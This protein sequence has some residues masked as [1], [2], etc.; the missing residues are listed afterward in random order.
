MDCF[1]CRA[2]KARFC[3]AC[4]QQALTERH[5]RLSEFAAEKGRLEGAMVAGLEQR[6]SLLQHAEGAR[7]HA[8]LKA[9][10]T[11]EIE[12]VR[13][14]TDRLARD[15]NNERHSLRR[16]KAQLKQHDEVL[17]KG[18]HTAW[19]AESSASVE[20]LGAETVVGRRITARRKALLRQLLLLHEAATSPTLSKRHHVPAVAT[21]PARSGG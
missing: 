2:S 12:A 9:S 7:A 6:R 20:G 13:R 18:R 14:D 3:A 8:A 17:P 19:E 10:L 1:A 21:E 11:A 16:A 4:V 15:V 5:V